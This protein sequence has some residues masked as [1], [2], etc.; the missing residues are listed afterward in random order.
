MSRFCITEL[1]ELSDDEGWRIV[2][3][4]E[5]KGQPYFMYDMFGY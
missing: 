4:V 3:L 2:G 5:H 1:G